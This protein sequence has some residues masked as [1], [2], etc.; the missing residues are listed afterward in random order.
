MQSIYITNGVIGGI[1]IACLSGF[2]FLSKINKSELWRVIVTPL[3][4]I[5]GSG[6][7]VVAPLMYA[8]FGIWSIP[9]VLVLNIFA[10]GV[11]WAIRVNIKWFDPYKAAFQESKKWVV[12]L[13]KLSN[14]ALGAS[15]MVAIAFY[16]SLLS[17]F[18]FE[19][20]KIHGDTILFGFVHG[21]QL[22]NTLS[23]VILSFIALFGLFKGLH[24]LENLEK[25][26][27]NLKLAVIGALLATL[28]IYAIASFMGMTDTSY[29]YTF[30]QLNGH[31]LQI[32][33]G[34]L[35]IT[36]GFET[37]KFLGDEYAVETRNK[38]MLFA[39]VI[40]LVIYVIFV[41]LAGPLTATLTELHETAIIQ[42]ISQTAF[43]MGVVL[44]LAAI[45]SQFGAAVAD[46]IGA[47]GLVEEE[48]GRRLTERQAY[49]PVGGSAILL[50]WLLPIFKIIVIA[51]RLF[52]LYYLFQTI[53]AIAIS[54]DQKNY[55]RTA[56]FSGIAFVLLFIVLFAISSH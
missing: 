16:V 30:V 28:G 13:E 10:L 32:L 23:T 18:V 54:I 4:S 29:V 46:T 45:F 51:S 41:P 21:K 52:A 17:S 49:L 35:L 3:A 50:I 48:S 37:V 11:G 33:G 42:I 19:L 25:I 26:A 7:L 56:L 5:I 6:F 27:V 2:F 14:F 1:V 12:V 47:S 15:Y 55:V 40:A 43:G 34:L 31:K 9:L 24:G 44:S 36:Q 39:Q 53:I 20:F 8:D 38:A 22:I